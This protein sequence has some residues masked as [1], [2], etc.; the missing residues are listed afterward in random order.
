MGK[1]RLR[2]WP[3]RF[4]PES[5]FQLATVNGMAGFLPT[6]GGI[7]AEVFLGG[8]KM[9]VQEGEGPGINSSLIFQGQG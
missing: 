4:V 2:S 6:V 9:K 1:S 3:W 5:N 7:D 8:E